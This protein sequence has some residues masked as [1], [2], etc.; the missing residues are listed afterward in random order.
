MVT[1][2]NLRG[3][4]NSSILTPASCNVNGSTFDQLICQTS[5][6]SNGAHAAVGYKAISAGTTTVYVTMTNINNVNPKALVVYCVQGKGLKVDGAGQDP[7]KVGNVTLSLS[8][9]CTEDGGAVFIAA[10]LRG[11]ITLG[12]RTNFDQ[13]ELFTGSSNGRGLYGFREGLAAGT[14]AYSQAVTG[15]TAARHMAGMLI[16]QTP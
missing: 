8:L 7:S 15:S 9:P 16:T 3:G 10:S 5:N 13:D 2:A 12:T 14:R 4:S 6:D 11:T 1:Y